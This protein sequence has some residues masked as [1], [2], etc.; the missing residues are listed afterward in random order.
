MFQI[1]PG[2]IATTL[3]GGINPLDTY[4]PVP[5]SLVFLRAIVNPQTSFIVVVD[6]EDVE[7][8]SDS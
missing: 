3:P 2:Y 4:T 5:L 1:L 6:R 7:I 8:D